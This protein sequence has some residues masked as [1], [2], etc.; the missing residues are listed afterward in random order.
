MDRLFGLNLSVDIPIWSHDIFSGT[1]C[2][3]GSA[4]YHAHTIESVN[5]YLHGAFHIFKLEADAQV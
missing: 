1:E 4:R 3:N 5:N 2:S